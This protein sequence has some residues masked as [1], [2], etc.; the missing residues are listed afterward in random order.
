MLARA[1]QKTAKEIV[2]E[3]VA[4]VAKGS[5]LERA[6]AEMKS[7]SEA[8]KAAVAATREAIAANSD[9]RNVAAVNECVQLESLAEKAAAA[10]RD[11]VQPLRLA[12]AKRLAAALKEVR[13]GAA[14]RIIDAL[15]EIVP[16]LQVLNI[17]MLAIESLGG[18]CVRM[19]PVRFDDV[20]H[21]ARRIARS[22]Q[23]GAET[24]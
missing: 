9:Q 21:V 7:A 11:R 5:A 15:T 18:E 13:T 16:A 6:E 3:I 2:A 19:P 23:A 24:R 12:H 22:T 4:A 1:E 20:E 8:L 14:G 10:A 17:S